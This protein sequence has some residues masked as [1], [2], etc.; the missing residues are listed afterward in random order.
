MKQIICK[1]CGALETPHRYVNSTNLIEKQLC[2][3]CNFWDEKIPLYNNKD[4]FVADGIMYYIGPED[5]KDYFRGF[6]GAHAVI[7]FMDGSV[8]HTTNLWCTGDV[9]AH[10]KDVLKDNAKLTW[11]GTDINVKGLLEEES[12]IFH[13]DG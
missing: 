2:F 10:F 13:V 5:S 4:R 11:E 8:V 1:L 7:T 12:K 6:G 3:S 9:P